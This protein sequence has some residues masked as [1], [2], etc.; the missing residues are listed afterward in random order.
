MHGCRRSGGILRIVRPRS[1]PAAVLLTVALTLFPASDGRAAP[2]DAQFV[3]QCCYLQLE[4]GEVRSDQ[5]FQL[6]NTGTETWRRSEA[7]RLGIDHPNPRTSLFVHPSWI[8]TNRPSALAEETVAAGGVGTFPFTIKAPSVSSS[9]F[10]REH[11]MALREEVS[12]FGPYMYLDYTVLPSVPPNVSITGLPAELDAGATLDATAVATDN[13]AVAGVEFRIDDGAVRT[14]TV[15]SDGRTF[16]AR[17]DT[18]SLGLG[19]HRLTV[20]AVDRVGNGTSTEQTFA[21]RP[22]SAPAQQPIAASGPSAPATA[23]RRL[24]ALKPVFAT[25]ANR[26]KR[27][28]TLGRLF[29]AE[30]QITGGS[31]LEIVCARGCK[32]SRTLKRVPGTKPKRL[33]VT[34][35]P[36]WTLKRGAVVEIRVLRKGFA[37]RFERYR[38]TR[39]GL[40]LK[41]KQTG[42]GCLASIR[43]RTL[44]KCPAA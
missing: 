32:R 3:G 38:F 39:S 16:T 35:R 15:G 19:Q 28:R 43:P 9:T 22:T 14:G 1:L 17:L 2:W 26:R 8:A 5:F 7:V 23:L 13:N 37:T 4:S 31:R 12:W 20:R 41:A 34:L 11:F 36:A 25:R 33:A 40:G 24:A 27:S 6:R 18:S 10:F 30:V 42:A 29:T 21:V 44:L